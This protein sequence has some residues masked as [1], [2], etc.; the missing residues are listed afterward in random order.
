M[1]A[2]TKNYPFDDSNTQSGK[3]LWNYDYEVRRFSS[4]LQKQE[5][6]TLH[7]SSAELLKKIAEIRIQLTQGIW[8]GLGIDCPLPYDK[9]AEA[10]YQNGNI[11]GVYATFL[12]TIQ[13][14]IIPEPKEGEEGYCIKQLHPTWMAV[15]A[16]YHWGYGWF[17]DEEWRAYLEERD[18]GLQGVSWGH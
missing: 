2:K 11:V 15:K 10:E 17:T 9:E 3:M 18:R 4:W 13:E 14:R 16:T 5:F 12:K 8:I 6:V 7:T 1:K